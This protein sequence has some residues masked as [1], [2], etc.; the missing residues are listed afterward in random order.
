MVPQQAEPPT[1]DHIAMILSQALVSGHE[2]PQPVK[3][4]SHSPR[5]EYGAFVA[6]ALAMLL[7]VGYVS[8]IRQQQASR[9]GRR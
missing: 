1:P 9:R 8:K 7:L 3:T 4:S 5:R 2:T 6:I